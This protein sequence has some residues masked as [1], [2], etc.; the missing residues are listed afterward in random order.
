MQVHVSKKPLAS[1]TKWDAIFENDGV[2][3]Y[4]SDK[5]FDFYKVAPKNGGKSKTFFGETAWMDTQRYAV[6]ESDFSAYSIF[7]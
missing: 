3:V 2:I 1:S 7:H 4:E 5:Y 6:D